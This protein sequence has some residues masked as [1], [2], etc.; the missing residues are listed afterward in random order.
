VLPAAAIERLYDLKVGTTPVEEGSPHER[1][2]KPLMLMAALDLIDEGL[3]RCR[4]HTAASQDHAF[5]P[6]AE[7][8]RT[9]FEN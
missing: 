3:A 2:H 1:P 5:H 8:L 4:K 7:G 6:D 9:R